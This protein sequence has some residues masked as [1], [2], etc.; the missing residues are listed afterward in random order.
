LN[1]FFNKF[2][3]AGMGLAIFITADTLF[4]FS[5]KGA[6]GMSLIDRLNGFLLLAPII[7]LFGLGLVLTLR[8]GVVGVSNGQ[9][10]RLVGENL[11]RTVL[12]LC[13][14]LIALAI[15]DQIVGM[16]LMPVW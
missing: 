12:M 3:H 5:P 9:R 6:Y 15:I 2:R 4:A 11:Y 13:A 10:L 14:A 1:H 8:S 16:H 7:A